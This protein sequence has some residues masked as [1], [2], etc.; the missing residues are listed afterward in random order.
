M[1]NQRMTGRAGAIPGIVAVLVVGFVCRGTGGEAL[2]GASAVIAVLSEA[3]RGVATQS[4]ADAT[5]P[6]RVFAADLAS[7]AS[8]SAAMPPVSAADAWLGFWDRYWKLPQAEG[9]PTASCEMPAMM[10]YRGRSG[11]ENLNLSHVLAAIPGPAAWP[12]LQAR[13]AGRKAD[14]KSQLREAEL[15][16]FT[17]L[18][19]RNWSDAAAVLGET[20]RSLPKDNEGMYTYQREQLSRVRRD[21]ERLAQGQKAPGTAAEF[22]RL[23]DALAGLTTEE[24]HILIPDLAAIVGVN[25][26]TRLIEKAVLVPNA[27]ITVKGGPDTRR[28]V[29]DSVLRHLDL[30]KKPQWGLVR[31]SDAVVLYE[32]MNKRFPP[33]KESEISVDEGLNENPLVRVSR[34]YSGGGSYERKTAGAFYVRGLLAL[35]R[36]DDAVRFAAEEEPDLYSLARRKGEEDDLE[37]LPVDT[38]RFVQALLKVKPGARVWG[39]LVASGMAAG[40]DAEVLAALAAP[41]APLPEPNRGAEREVEIAN[42]YFALDKVDD[43]I[44]ILRR[45]LASEKPAGASRQALRGFEAARRQAI[46]RM[47]TVGCLLDRQDLVQEGLD[48]IARLVRAATSE[49]GRDE[50]YESFGYEWHDL[51]ERLTALGRYRQAEDLTLELLRA[52]MRSNRWAQGNEGSGLLTSL[53]RL[54]GAAGRSADVLTLLEKAPG[55]GVGDL[56]AFG[57]DASLL[58]V[59]A[60]ALLAE[61]RTNEARR[62]ARTALMVQP[63][64][65]DAYAVLLSAGGADLAAE[66][67]ALYARDRFEERPLIWKAVW[68]LRNGETAKA[69]EAVRE[70]IRV[71]PTDG[72]TRPGYR[73]RSYSVLADVLEAR[74]KKED[75]AGL[76]NV[77]AAVRLAEKGDALTEAGLLRRSLT[78][79]DQASALFSDAYCVQWRLAERLYATGHQAEAEKHY[80]VVFER[81]PEQFGRVASLCFGCEGVFDRTQ[82]RSVAERILTRLATNATV[83]PQV[84]FLIGQLREAQGRYP[85]AY[86]AFRKA[87][88]IDPD[89]LDGWRQIASIAEEVAIPQTE[90]DDIYL[91]MLRLDPLGAHASAEVSRITDLKGVWEI[92]AANQKLAWEPPSQLFPL[93]ASKAALEKKRAATADAGMME[94]QGMEDVGSSWIN[95]RRIPRPGEAVLSCSVIA[96]TL[97]AFACLEQ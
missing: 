67:D 28:L 38:F 8:N 97:Q 6:R 21:I 13:T 94:R 88:A 63:G 56:I 24:V 36:Q 25:E 46:Q 66:W 2:Q 54:Y 81:M 96:G 16:A 5:A 44:A 93:T 4:V 49:S 29:K 45:V 75:A 31:G 70:A 19:N 95:Y 35:N 30:L 78:C 47:V 23:I 1:K 86:Q 33:V 87:V 71:D 43:G 84:F 80:A 39:A 89:Y 9:F 34:S 82:S 22:E 51:L 62:V 20:L 90:R 7:F 60:G 42:G 68:L 91:R 92:M 52:A 64:D 55:W 26:A 72:E 17:L 53:A 79:Y 12:I 41:R 32:A 83:R 50:C 77:V 27:Q 69:E 73:V 14:E 59:S 58:S 3:A 18:L 61:G 76:R 10:M 40:L 85:E 48:A 57:S 11:R 37:L 15:R 74:G 65:D